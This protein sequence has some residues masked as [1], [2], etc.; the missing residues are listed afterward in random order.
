MVHIYTCSSI[1]KPRNNSLDMLH[2]WQ[3]HQKWATLPIDFG[4]ETF[5][6]I[7]WKQCRNVGF[8][9]P[10]WIILWFSAF[11]QGRS[12]GSIPLL[13][14][15]CLFSKLLISIWSRNSAVYTAVNLKAMKFQE[16]FSLCIAVSFSE[17]F[18]HPRIQSRFVVGRSFNS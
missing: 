7:L 3:N 18:H 17:L 2:Y 11:A 4:L 5:V 1:Q 12:S 10:F 8:T 9:L 15:L 13:M 14:R 16:I 6:E